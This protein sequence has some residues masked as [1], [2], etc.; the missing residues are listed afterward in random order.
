MV[1]SVEVPGV[2]ADEGAD[3]GADDGG[4]PVEGVGIDLKDGSEGG[5]IAVEGVEGIVGAVLAPMVL[6]PE[7]SLILLP[8]LSLISSFG[9]APFDIALWSV[10]SSTV[11][12]CA[13]SSWPNVFRVSTCDASALE[14]ISRTR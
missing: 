14:T 7:A 9:E 8:V 2:D 5:A 11:I 10:V 6:L 13:S 4:V 1:L 3:G 12:S